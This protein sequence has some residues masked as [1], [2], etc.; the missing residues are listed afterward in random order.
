MSKP[1][2]AAEFAEIIEKWNAIEKRLKE[3]EQICGD[4]VV[5]AINELR[6]AGR[7]FVDA[8][9]IYARVPLTEED[10][11]SLQKHLQNVRYN[12]MNADHD[13]TDAVCL[14]FHERVKRILDEYGLALIIEYFPDYQE[15]FDRMDGA[16]KAIS[17]S[18]ED[19]QNRL[20]IYRA[21]ADFHVPR[22]YEFNQ[23]ILTSEPLMLAHQKR[24]VVKRNAAK[25]TSIILAI[26][27]AALTYLV[28]RLRSGVQ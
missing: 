5:A 18:R 27:V 26:L 4:A 9:T 11:A 1:D 19:R 17:A 6:Y 3:A 12:L 22:L 24:T 10:I 20:E 7:Q 13:C 16:N 21:L 2:F 25:I 28:I 23:V 15:L 8:M 14:F